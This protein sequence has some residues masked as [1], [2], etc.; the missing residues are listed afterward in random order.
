[1]KKI[2][3]FMALL[4][5]QCTGVQAQEPIQEPI[6]ETLSLIQELADLNIQSTPWDD[7]E[8]WDEEDFAIFLKKYL[9]CLENPHPRFKRVNAFKILKT[10]DWIGTSGCIMNDTTL[11]ND[12][13]LFAGRSKKSS[14]VAAKLDRTTTE[15]GKTTLYALLAHPTADTQVI[16]QRQAVVHQLLE[17]EA[18]FE[19]LTQSLQKISQAE[20]LVFS[21]FN[22]NVLKNASKYCYFSNILSPGNSSA[23]ALQIRSIFQHVIRSYGAASSGIATLALCAYGLSELSFSHNNWLE[24]KAQEYKNDAGYVVR[25][26][27]PFL[28]YP[29]LRGALALGGSALCAGMCYESIKWEQACTVLEVMLQTITIRI[30]QL[31]NA[32]LEMTK[33]LERHLELATHEDFKP[34]FQL[35]KMV[36]QESGEVAALFALFSSDTLQ[37]EASIISLQ[38]TALRA[39]KLFDTLKESFI[40]AFVAGA[41]LDA[42]MSC[43]RL[44][45]ESASQPVKFTFAQFC[46][47]ATPCIQAEKVWH[48]FIDPA[49][50]VAH[51]Y[52]L[53]AQRQA[54]T[55]IITG[56]NEG[57]KSTILK[58]VSLALLMAQTIG[59]VPA[60]KFM[61][62]PFVTIA[63]YLTIADDTASGDSLFRA[64]AIRAG[65]L[66]DKIEAA[67]EGEFVF[68]AFD[69]LF[70]GTSPEEGEAAAFSVV[71]GIGQS[72]Y[73]ISLVATHFP[74]LNS[75]ADESSDF[76]NH[77]ISINFHP[78]GRVEY[79]YS[80]E[81]GISNQHVALHVLRSQGISHR[82]L[83]DALERLQS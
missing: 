70:S 60:Q 32:M 65:Q 18:L 3:V 46:D 15:L 13:D 56:P 14:Y 38:G 72:P 67:K 74:L 41:K 47:N 30:A 22:Q 28:A 81:P 78:D 16:T 36:E 44:I 1:M 58:E 12:L 40:Q 52:A 68:T 73:V 31:M 82:F 66:L 21:L 10:I 26:L 45:K 33:Q 69:E 75:L 6:N 63:T 51:D 49:H 5:V 35:K 80:L 24:Q 79:P 61:T 17:D 43:A 23:L 8:W 4:A 48:P 37:G 64:S 7:G 34:L 39:F 29:L 62:T 2:V 59:I 83:D 27:W 71:K 20:P 19:N 54:R 53:G 9:H 50:V 42:Y 11:W 77:K 57:G 25:F 55:M 76:S